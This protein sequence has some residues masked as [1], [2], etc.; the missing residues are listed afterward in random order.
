MIQQAK[1]TPQY[2]NKDQ[3][4]KNFFFRYYAIFLKQ[5]PDAQSNDLFLYERSASLE[6]Y[7]KCSCKTKNQMLCNRCQH[8]Y[9]GIKGDILKASELCK[10]VISICIGL[11]GNFRFLAGTQNNQKENED[12]VINANP[13]ATEPPIESQISEEKS[14]QFQAQYQENLEKC[15][16]LGYTGCL[17]GLY[18]T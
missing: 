17:Y 12:M 9:E 5:Q 14:Y 7:L 3:Y 18:W 15:D 11:D 16:R 2:L 4:F 8:R 1:N 10:I 6:V 13:Y